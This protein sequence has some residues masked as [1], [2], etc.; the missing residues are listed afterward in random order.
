MNGLAAETDHLQ[1]QEA[2]EIQQLGPG[3]EILQRPPGLQE[4]GI[5]PLKARLGPVRIRATMMTDDLPL[6]VLFA[7]EVG[8]GRVS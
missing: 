2:L 1:T 5:R 7:C 8:R 4:C 3:P 6:D